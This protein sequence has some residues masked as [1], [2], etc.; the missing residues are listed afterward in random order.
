MSFGWLERT[1][2]RLWPLAPCD[3]T[4]EPVPIGPREILAGLVPMA[5]GIHCSRNHVVC[6]TTVAATSAVVSATVPPPL[7]TPVRHDTAGRH[8]ADRVGNRLAN[9]SIR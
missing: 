7:P 6:S 1:R 3:Q 4:P 9:A 8:L 2:E 5:V